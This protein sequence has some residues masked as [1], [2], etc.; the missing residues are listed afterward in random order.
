[1]K[2]E[3]LIER[4]M[5]EN[6]IQIDEI[7]TISGDN[8]L[9]GKYMFQRDK[10]GRLHLYKDNQ[11]CNLSVIAQFVFGCKINIQKEP[12]EPEEGQTY[13]YIA[14]KNGYQRILMDLY[15]KRDYMSRINFLI[16]NCFRTE[17]EAQANEDKILKILENEKP[18]INLNEV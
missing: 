17:L 4:F 5:E 6:G 12:F 13:Y 10:W 1:M 7:I 14:Y 11:M 15:Y 9:Q 3:H 18:L 2:N 8:E 16:G